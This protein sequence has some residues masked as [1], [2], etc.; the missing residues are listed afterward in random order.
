MCVKGYCLHV[1]NFGELLLL[2]QHISVCKTDT[3][4]QHT[5]YFNMKVVIL[6]YE[7]CS[8]YCNI[9]MCKGRMIW[10]GPQYP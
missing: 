4:E 7:H 10:Q 6:P 5:T 8:V 9:V 2:E 3:V 1:F